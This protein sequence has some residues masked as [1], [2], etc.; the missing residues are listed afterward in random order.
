MSS[1]FIGA[2][3]LILLS[4]SV[5]AWSRDMDRKETTNQAGARVSAAVEY[6]PIKPLSFKVEEELR[7]IAGGEN[8]SYTDFEAEYKLFKHFKIGAGYTYIEKMEPDIDGVYE[9]KGKHRFHAGV[10]A[11]YKFGHLKVSASETFRSTIKAYESN[12][13]Q[14]PKNNLSLKTKMKFALDL[15][16]CPYT[17][18]LS[19]EMKTCLNAVDVNSLGTTKETAG[20]VSYTDVYNDRYSAQAGVQ[21]KINRK[22]HLDL[23]FYY[24]HGQEKVIDTNKSGKLKECFI[25][26][27]NTFSLGLSYSFSL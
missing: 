24:S 17:P 27:M 1:R 8:N 7:Y 4:S 2:A 19:A 11:S 23:Y 6:R 9:F 14:S 10:G 5:A 20:T 18:Y 13:F 21:W 26:P 16:Y 15:P 12:L 3:A 25:A 22:N